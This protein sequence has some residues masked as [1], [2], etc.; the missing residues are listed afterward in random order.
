MK[1]PSNNS[2]TFEY[3]DRE[4]DSLFQK[5]KENNREGSYY[6]ILLTGPYKK[7]KKNFIQKLAS[8]TNR[9]VRHI[10]TR[11]IVSMNEKETEKKIDSLFANFSDE[12]KILFFSNGDRLCGAYAG[13]T[14]SKTRYAT[15]QERY[16]IGKL[17]DIPNIVVIDI[18][19]EDNIDKTMERFSHVLIRFQKPESF[20]KRLTWKLGNVNF[21][22]HNITSKR[23]V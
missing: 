16:L 1:I 4:I 9:N 20:F 10:D 8:K 12:N 15:P 21:H 5:L 7:E 23:P 11:E 3:H 19:E 14:Y 6:L 17:G 2:K 22:G 18:E 13:F